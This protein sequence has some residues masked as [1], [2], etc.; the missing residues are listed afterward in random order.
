MKKFSNKSITSL[1]HRDS[2]RSINNT[3]FNE[4]NQKE[5]E[6]LENYLESMS[7]KLHTLLS[8]KE[9][10]LHKEDS[11][12]DSHNKLFEMNHNNYLATNS[13]LTDCH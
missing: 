2:L 13:D 3:T 6:F 5:I 7:N 8:T 10:Y 1:Q 4:E 12:E 11:I 9:Q